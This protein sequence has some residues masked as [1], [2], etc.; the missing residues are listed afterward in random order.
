L[1]IV[2]R[3]APFDHVVHD[4]VIVI[5]IVGLHI[6]A[7]Y[8][9]FWHVNGWRNER[10]QPYWVGHGISTN[11]L[12]R[13]G[14]LAVESTRGLLTWSDAESRAIGV[15]LRS[16]ACITTSLNMGEIFDDVELEPPS[17]DG[18]RM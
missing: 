6:F 17:H 4:A 18:T 13:V 12:W 14:M 15:L 1:L 16:R 5:L 7:H 9:P 10:F 2:H 8:K 11:N 3:I